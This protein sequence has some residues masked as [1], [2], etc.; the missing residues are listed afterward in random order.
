[1]E[2]ESTAAVVAELVKTHLE[3]KQMI[4]QGDKGDGQ[5][6]VLIVPRDL[7]VVDLQ[8]FVDPYLPNPRRRTGVA[9][10]LT[11]ESFIDL[12]NRFKDD[13]S[14][15]FADNGDNTPG[16]L[17][18]F[19]YNDR[20]NV[21]GEETPSTPLPRFGEHCAMYSFPKSPEWNAWMEFQKQPMEQGEFAVFMEE[22]AL[23][24]LPVPDMGDPN[25][26]TF[27]ELAKLL[28]GTFAGP[29]KMM[30]LSRGLSVIEASE[31]INLV[32]ISSGE[33]TMNFASEHQDEEGVKLIVPN[34]FL[35]GIPV[36]KNGPSYRMACRLRYRK[37]SG[38][39]V[40]T[41]EAYRADLSFK[42]AVEE[43][44]GTAASETGLPV[45]FGI[46]EGFPKL[47]SD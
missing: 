6:E 33:G 30:D 1:M 47:A 37:K 31:T 15:I 7:K 16:L 35:I 32:N 27:K 3:V 10:T 11:L 8:K 34:L 22:R 2:E 25:N 18:V 38:S 28:G 4:I 41:Y 24:L 39:I 19:D 40:W 13:N 21:D 9:K 5:A 42:D 44:A 46:P 23:D 14:A 43:A 12:T 26:S 36:F 20:L 29:E 45:Y 17:T